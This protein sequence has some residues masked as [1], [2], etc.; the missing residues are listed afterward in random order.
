MVVFFIWFGF[1]VMRE[2]GMDLS[3]MGVRKVV[4]V[5]D[6]IVDQLQVM[7]VVWEVFDSQLGIEYKVFN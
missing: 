3:N 7:R 6:K 1:G 5:I 2:V 4:V